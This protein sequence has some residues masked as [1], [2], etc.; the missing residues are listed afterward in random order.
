[1]KVKG[2]IFVYAQDIMTIK[3]VSM[4]SAVREIRLIRDVFDKQGKDIT[5]F[6]CAKF[7]DID[8]ELLIKLINE[9]R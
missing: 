6:D 3:G 2:G 9:N 7:W 4:R 5:V 8:V 1:M